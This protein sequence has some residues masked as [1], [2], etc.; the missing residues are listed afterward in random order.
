MHSKKETLLK[1]TIPDSDDIEISFEYVNTYANRMDEA[2]EAT[3]E[4]IHSIDKIMKN[5]S[6]PA[7]KTYRGAVN[8]EA[9]AILK[10]GESGYKLPGFISTSIDKNMAK[11]FGQKYLL[12]IDV[13]KGSKGIFLTEGMADTPHEK[14]LLLNRNY[15]IVATS[16]S[17]DKETGKTIIHTKIV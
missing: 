17:E 14:E 11:D 16:T 13:P 10:S 8:Q 1:Y 3:V 7:G 12:E 6:L 15:K 2:P 4:T 9:E 5:T